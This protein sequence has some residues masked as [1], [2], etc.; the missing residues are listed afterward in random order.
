VANHIYKLGV[1][2]EVRLYNY[3]TRYNQRGQKGTLGVVALHKLHA[4]VKLRNNNQ[5]NVH[6]KLHEQ[7]QL[8]QLR[9]APE[10]VGKPTPRQLSTLSNLY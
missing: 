10:E 6:L 9:A 3:K 1:M 7:L 8:I 4:Q 5:L 2:E